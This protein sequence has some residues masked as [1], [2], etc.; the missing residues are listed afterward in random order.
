MSSR[1]LF[2]VAVIALSVCF[3]L[4]VW[5]GS[6]ARFSVHSSGA[7]WWVPKNWRVWLFGEVPTTRHPDISK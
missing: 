2:V 6:L 3:R 1:T 5:F 4:L 7:L